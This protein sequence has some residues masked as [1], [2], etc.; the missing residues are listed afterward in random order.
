MVSAV[1]AEEIIIYI[2]LKVL[3]IAVGMHSSQPVLEITN[4]NMKH[5]E[6]LPVFR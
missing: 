1:A 6:V 4:L 2:F 3:G 5:F